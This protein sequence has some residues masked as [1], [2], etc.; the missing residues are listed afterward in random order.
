MKLKK[1]V[2]VFFT[3]STSMSLL[4][5]AGSAPAEGDDYIDE[6]E[7]NQHLDELSLTLDRNSIY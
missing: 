3:L 6:V 2:S 7:F 5:F 1:I 4:S